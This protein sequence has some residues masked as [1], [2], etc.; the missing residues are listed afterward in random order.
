M[1]FFSFQTPTPRPLVRKLC[2]SITFS[3]QLSHLLISLADPDCDI[4]CNI[5]FFPE[6][7]CSLIQNQFTEAQLKHIPHSNHNPQT[8]S[9]LLSN[10]QRY[11][12]CQVVTADIAEFI[13]LTKHFING[14]HL[15]LES[16]VEFCQLEL[17][18]FEFIF[19]RKQM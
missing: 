6:F 16:H 8:R 3:L 11:L 7:I 14:A 13:N 4:N 2:S 10:N 17:V 19:K 15:L 18:F 1:F 5:N 9:K 12:F